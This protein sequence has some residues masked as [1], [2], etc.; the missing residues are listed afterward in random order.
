MDHEELRDL[1]PIYAL[2]ALPEDE[3]AT[4]RWHLR[5]CAECCWE[6]LVLTETAVAFAKES[7]RDARSRLGEL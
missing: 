3:R 4:V 6:A 5:A 2:G 1:L 7:L